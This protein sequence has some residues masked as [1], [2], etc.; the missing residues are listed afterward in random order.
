MELETQSL[1]SLRIIDLDVTPIV[2]DN[3]RR[4]GTVIGSADDGKPFDSDDAQL[5]LSRGAP[6]FYI[7]NLPNRG[8]TFRQITRHLQVTQCLA[9]V[10][11][12]PWLIAVAPPLELN[13][14][15]ACP[16]PAEICAFQVPGD[17]A[18]QLHRGTWH[19]GPY[20]TEPS[21]AFF[22]LELTDTNQVDHHDCYLDQH[23]GIQMRF[24]LA[25]P[26]LGSV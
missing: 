1:Q 21:R 19:A 9:A 8:L 18:I 12:K 25:S 3:F 22:N 16:D 23:Y 26:P 7:M 13:N 10:G 24:K 5:D 11:G 6:R 15:A 14:G 2:Y 20:F 4:F 17:R